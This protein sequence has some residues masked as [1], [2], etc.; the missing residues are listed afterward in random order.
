MFSLQVSKVNIWEGLPEISS[1]RIYYKNLTGVKF[2]EFRR[3]FGVREIRIQNYHCLLQVFNLGQVA[4][5]PDLSFLSV[6]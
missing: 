5:S 2:E 4:S 6:R 3:I 1:L